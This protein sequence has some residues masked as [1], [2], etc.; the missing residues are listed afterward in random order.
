MSDEEDDRVGVV[1]RE[2]IAEMCDVPV[3]TVHTVQFTWPADRQQ[4]TVVEVGIFED[5]PDYGIN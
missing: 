3:G 1:I 4:P 5:A 2:M